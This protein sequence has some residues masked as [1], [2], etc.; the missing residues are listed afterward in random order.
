MKPRT[1]SKDLNEQIIF[2]Q[3]RAKDGVEYSFGADIK[4]MEVDPEKEL[5]NALK[6]QH[7]IV[8]QAVFEEAFQKLF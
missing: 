1:F 7:S 4:Y 6:E 3:K 8:E 5:F 2:C